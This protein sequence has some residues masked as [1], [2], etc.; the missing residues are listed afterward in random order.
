MQ[1]IA[2]TF[3]C[4]DGSLNAYL[5]K[6]LNIVALFDD[7]SVQHV[8]RDENIVANDLVHEASDF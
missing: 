1:Q 7:F 6:C 8:S 2:G 5:G 3:Q 4:L